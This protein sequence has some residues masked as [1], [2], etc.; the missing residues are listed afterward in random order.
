MA[1]VRLGSSVAT[2]GVEIRV[3]ARKVNA[4]TFSDALNQI[5]T[6]FA[7]A[8]GSVILLKIKL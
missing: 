1:L 4:M 6:I 8:L 2:K 7:H 3:K 5:L